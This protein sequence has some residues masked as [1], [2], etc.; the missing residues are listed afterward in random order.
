M[1]AE[2]GFRKLLKASGIIMLIGIAMLLGDA[3]FPL[4]V[5]AW[6]TRTGAAFTIAGACLELA[7]VWRYLRS[8][9]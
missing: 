2:A 7:A 9:R 1:R 4:S 3:L 8:G 6:W 5:P